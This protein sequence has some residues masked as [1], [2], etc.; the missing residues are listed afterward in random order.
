MSDDKQRGMINWQIRDTVVEYKLLI[1]PKVT[2]DMIP[3]LKQ[4]AD[5]F[6]IHN[7]KKTILLTKM[8]YPKIG[9]RLIE[10]GL[11][12]IDAA[13]N[14]F[15]DQN[16]VYLMRLGLKSKVLEKGGTS[17]RIFGE[18]GLKL[19]FGILHNPDFINLSYREM[20]AAV[21]I[22]AA[23]VTILLKEM[24]LSKFL[25]EGS[26]KKKIINNKLELLQRWSVAYNEILKPK[27]KVGEYITK[28]ENLLKNYTDIKPQQ[29]EGLWSA[30]VAGNKL[31]N[32]LSPGK[33]A[34]FV[35]DREKKWMSDLKL[36]PVEENGVIEIFNFFWNTKHIIF[37]ENNLLQDAVPPLLIY[38]D[39]IT[40]PDS[41]NIETARKIFDEYI[42]FK[43]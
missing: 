21:E 12:F 24:M 33:L 25:Y 3:L 28:G 11:N 6:D 40:S 37:T 4:Y 34:M 32:Y 30:E 23:S 13:G 1:F 19:L 14:I 7:H 27:M 36:I 17:G 10:A 18:A 38:A 41:R 5:D 9:E 26:N 35:P 22:S 39:L 31:T 16:S 29:W 42:Q 8:I 20:A 2:H 43:N 15:I